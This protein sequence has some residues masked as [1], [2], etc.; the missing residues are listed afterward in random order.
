MINL[1]KGLSID[2]L[3]AYHKEA[4]REY[5]P[6]LRRAKVLDATDRGKLWKA[7][8]A[9]FPKY[10]VLPDTN[11]VSYVKNNLL[12]SIYSVGR[13]AEISPTSEEDIEVC[14][15]LNLVLDHI[16]R[17]QRVA[18]Y[19]MQAGERAALLNLGLTQVGWD[20][21]IIKGTEET[22]FKG[23]I[24]LKNIDPMRYMRDPHAVDLDS[25]A[26]QMTWD[27]FHKETIKRNSLYSKEFEEY[28]KTSPANMT[29]SEPVKPMTDQPNKPNKDRYTIYTMW[30]RHNKAIHEIH[31][32]NM[33]HILYIKED[34]KPSM[35]PIVE[36]Y[37]NLPVG[38]IIGTSEPS[39]ILANSIAANMMNS[40][41]LTAEVK[42]QRP[43]R[44][45]NTQS[46][47]NLRDFMDHGADSDWVFQVQGDASRAVH[48]HQFPQ[49]SAVAQSIVS[50]LGFDIQQISGVDGKYTGKDT[51]SIL[52]TGG[53][54]Q[55]LD[56]ATLIDAPKVVNYEEYTV[57]LTQLI[58]GNLKQ[59]GQRR[60]YF[61]KDP[62]TAKVQVITVNY[63][64]LADNTV[65]EYGLDIT[66]YLP[67]NRQRI[68]QMANIIM[69]KQMQ[70]QQSN[71]N[72]QVTL[73]TPEEWLL[74]Q[75][76]PYKEYMLKR[77]GVERH[78]DYVDKVS[79]VIF[80]YA[81]LVENGLDPE[82][83][84]LQTADSMRQGDMSLQDPNEMMLQEPTF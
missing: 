48:Y 71:P 40:I 7:I 9:K 84:L 44:F 66:A 6:A 3:K 2:T 52:T 77:M 76:L 56:Q 57:R 37:C 55:M 16:W 5:T 79:K 15:H 64:D 19:Q 1:P 58:L 45:V 75:D 61:I 10:Q 24:S 20:N 69:E 28:L 14:T 50:G 51:G 46:Q 39:K 29:T 26:Y 17:T 8:G 70:Y 60:N 13:T 34:I 12:A 59:Y 72:G 81:H 62:T 22:F 36:L 11:H 4:E 54:E 33:E 30:I 21:N 78:K 38:D 67:R 74:M 83:A 42:N 47:I 31:L 49:V 18:Y 23:N 43:P 65:F 41:I 32:V 63:D 82:E 73:I 53:I 27:T 68:A 25:A 80:Q 35:F